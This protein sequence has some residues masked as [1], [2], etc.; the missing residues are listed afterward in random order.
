[1]QCGMKNRIFKKKKS[2]VKA[3]VT[4]YYYQRLFHTLK[5]KMLYKATTA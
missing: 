5:T 1:M 4:L 3:A 2:Q